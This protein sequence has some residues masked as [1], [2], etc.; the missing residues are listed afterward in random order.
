MPSVF[1]I[2]GYH[3]CGTDRSIK[4]RNQNSKNQTKQK[5]FINQPIPAKNRAQEK[6]EP[7]THYFPLSRA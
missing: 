5:T 4:K 2:F 1:V 3:R 6:L 7:R